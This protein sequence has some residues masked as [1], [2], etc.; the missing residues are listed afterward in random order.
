MI[1]H[2]LVERQLGSKFLLQQG[3]HGLILQN[4]NVYKL[5]GF[6]GYVGAINCALC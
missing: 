4:Q 3:D 6:M 1:R 5:Y 2:D